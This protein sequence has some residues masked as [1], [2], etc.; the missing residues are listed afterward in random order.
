M[1]VYKPENVC[2]ICKKV[3]SRKADC[4]RHVRLHSGIKPYPCEVPGCGKRFAQFTALKTHR[5]V[6]TGLKPFKCEFL[7]CNATFGDPSS[8]ARHRRE[9]HYPGKAFKCPIA[10]CPSSIRRSSS[11]KTHLKKHGLD[12]STYLKFSTP[13]HSPVED[14]RS[15]QPEG[16]MEGQVST[17][18]G[19]SCNQE[20]I[21]ELGLHELWDSDPLLSLPVDPSVPLIL[22]PELI[23]V[24]PSSSPMLLAPSPRMAPESELFFAS[25][26]R[27]SP[28][29]SSRYSSPMATTPILTPEIE[30]A[31]L[32]D[33]GLQLGSCFPAH[34]WTQNAW[35]DHG[36]QFVG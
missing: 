10:G 7:G 22:Q 14:W 29:S 12:P 28:A 9:I 16:I 4:N 23:S 36:I 3:F 33:I 32:N 34:D 31:F 6:H 18:S 1:N 27:A 13:S 8:C 2:A 15:L 30:S 17:P 25:T 26:T 11:F 5:N 21:P 24:D 20:I 19:S 35:L